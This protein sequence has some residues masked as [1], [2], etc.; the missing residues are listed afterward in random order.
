M[1]SNIAHHSLIKKLAALALFAI[2]F[3]GTVSAQSVTAQAPAPKANLMIEHNRLRFD[4]QGETRNW[5]IEVF[6][7]AG[8]LIFGS[9]V[10]NNATLEWP[11]V[12]QKGEPLAG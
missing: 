5:Q 8:D 1:T 7:K 9:G 12:D 10:V 11:L 4:L 2:W 6:N 3:S